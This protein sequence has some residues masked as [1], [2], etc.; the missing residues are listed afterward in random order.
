MRFKK[1][2]STN[3]FIKMFMAPF[4]LVTVL[5]MRLL[6][7]FIHFKVFEVYKHRIGHFALET[8]LAALKSKYDSL[9][10]K[11][12]TIFFYFPDRPPANHQL[13]V[14]FRRELKCV[15]G[16]WGWLIGQ[17]SKFFK[18]MNITAQR[19]TI[20]RHGLLTKLPKMLEFTTEENEHRDIENLGL[21][22]NQ[23][24]VCLHVRDSA[25]ASQFFNNSNH[26]TFRNSH[27]ETFLNAS[28]VLANR[29]YV[30]FRTGVKVN[31]KLVSIDPMVVDYATNGMRSDFLDIYLG[32]KASFVISTASGWDS[33]PTIFRRPILRVNV[34][35]VCAYDNLSLEGVLVPKVLCDIACK[36]PL[37]LLQ[38]LD[39]G[40]QRLYDNDGYQD[41]GVEIRDLSSEELVEAVTEMAQRVEGTFVETPEQREMQSKLKHIL[42]THPKLQPSPNYYPIRAQFASCFLSRYPNFLDGL[43]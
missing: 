32:A 21:R 3:V 7:I 34:L 30:V 5:V 31:K 43:D 4:A 23:K 29:G 6:K 24:F 19:T 1:Y 18:D 25:F 42:S 2:L 20:D 26:Q 41:A 36:E 9:N 12:T 22:P 38:I 39:R 14:M 35:P 15:S 33:V 17:I 37:S 10:G 27:I 28:E 13:Q 16:N 40:V 8:E 11:K